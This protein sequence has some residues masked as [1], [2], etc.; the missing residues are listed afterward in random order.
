MD[1][2]DDDGLRDAL[3][4]LRRALL[5]VHQNPRLNA[6]ALPD[7]AESMAIVEGLWQA[8]ERDLV[9]LEDDGSYSLSPAAVRM[10]ERP[11]RLVS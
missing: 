2:N 7:T 3:V 11:V 6:D 9:V 5:A 4:S 8:L 10:V 1:G